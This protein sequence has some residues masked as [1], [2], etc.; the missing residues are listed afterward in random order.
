MILRNNYM[1]KRNNNMENEVIIKVS[2]LSK[3]Y[4]L[5]TIG[6]TTLRDE[7]QRRKA[8]RK[9]LEDPTSIVG[10]ASQIDGELFYALKDI[11]LT[12][13]K[14]EKLGI[15]GKNGAG[16]STLLRLLCNITAP[17]SGE[18]ELWGR[19]ASML[20]ICTG[21]HPELSG[22]EN[23]YMNGA[24]L[25]M[26]KKEIDSKIEQ[27]IDFSE[28]RKFIDTPVKR[29]SSGM[30]VKLG[31]SVAAHLESE[32]MIMDE[33]LAVGDA[34]FQKKCIHRM[35]ELASEGRTVLYVSHN[36]ETIR[37]LCYRVVVLNCGSK[38]FEGATEDGIAYY[39]S[40]NN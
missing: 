17:S 19:V 35:N 26:R 18:I 29:Y 39:M 24:I 28:C 36:M 21:F 2:G 27:I 32:I 7:L 25:G 4:R 37:N 38:V 22:R 20:E 33:V 31:F 23:I 12:V 6:S 11:N 13:H 14:G 16:K 8:K 34:G 9:G 3:I 15:V 30:Y 1:V 10:S 40:L 5:G